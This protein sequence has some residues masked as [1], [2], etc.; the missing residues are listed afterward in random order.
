[1]IFND[2]LIQRLI[3]SLTRRRKSVPSI[4]IKSE[5]YYHSNRL[6]L[7]GRYLT[8]KAGLLFCRRCAPGSGGSGSVRGL[9]ALTLLHGKLAGCSLDQTHLVD[10]RS[11]RC[12]K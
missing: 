1:M 9:A 4:G 12:S 2:R 3:E 7:P 11:P 10:G 8:F 6:N 5:M